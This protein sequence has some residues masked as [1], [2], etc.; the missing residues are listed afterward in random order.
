MASMPWCNVCCSRIRSQDKVQ[1]MV[2]SKM[3]Y[4][5]HGGA[6]MGLKTEFHPVVGIRS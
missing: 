2:L 3:G 4:Q 6:M 1:Q 5:G